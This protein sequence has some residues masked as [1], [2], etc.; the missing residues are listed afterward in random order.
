MSAFTSSSDPIPGS[1]Q[2]QTTVGSSSPPSAP[3]SSN[4][5]LVK[6]IED[7]IEDH[8]SQA[9]NASEEWNIHNSEHAEEVMP[10][11]EKMKKLSPVRSLP[12][13]KKEKVEGK[14]TLAL[15]TPLT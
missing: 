1:T 8:G 3:P 15:L 4:V 5:S 10:L 7:D 9:T 2:P 11:R 6:I 13:L 12:A 14:E